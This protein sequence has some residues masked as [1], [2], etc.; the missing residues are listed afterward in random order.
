MD[1]FVEVM[2]G[3]EQVIENLELLYQHLES[4]DMALPNTLTIVR[5]ARVPII[6]YIDS[7]GSGPPSP[8]L[9]PLLLS[10][11]LS[12]LLFF[13]QVPLLR[14]TKRHPSRHLNEQHLSNPL[15]RIHFPPPLLA[16]S[17]SSLNPGP[18]T[19]ALSAQDE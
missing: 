14:L 17:P 3:E 5:G 16:S 1:L 7:H 10:L 11:F 15:H 4:S 18:K 6:K 8:S 19:M 12:S 13:F 2:G 9:P